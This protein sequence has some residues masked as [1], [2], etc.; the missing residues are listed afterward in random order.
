M[1]VHPLVVTMHMSLTPRL[2]THPVT[3]KTTSKQSKLASYGNFKWFLTVRVLCVELWWP[4]EIWCWISCRKRAIQL[5]DVNSLHTPFSTPW[6]GRRSR[7]S[8]YPG[9]QSTGFVFLP[10]KCSCRLEWRRRCVSS[11]WRVLDYQPSQLLFIRSTTSLITC[12]IIRCV[13]INR[14]APNEVDD[15]KVSNT[16]RCTVVWKFRHSS[17]HCPSFRCRQSLWYGIPISKP[18]SNPNHIPNPN[19]YC[20]RLLTL[21][22]N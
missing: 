17:E 16:R 21:T 20:L 10:I 12:S 19:L 18:G 14:R 13:I 5:N 11:R 1:G 8:S 9:S 3:T 22:T 4:M 6:S 2:I 15:C 7:L